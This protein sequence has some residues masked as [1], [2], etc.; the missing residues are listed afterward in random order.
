MCV[1]QNVF[2]RLIPTQTHP[3]PDLGIYYNQKHGQVSSPRD[4][5]LLQHLSNKNIKGDERGGNL[6]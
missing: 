4:I 6:S 3:V 5:L 2:F 1:D